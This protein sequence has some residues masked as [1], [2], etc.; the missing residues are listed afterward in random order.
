[1]NKISIF[2]V[3]SL[4]SGCSGLKFS[5]AQTI[6]SIES[7]YTYIPI[8]PFSVQATPN[9]NCFPP[10]AAFLDYD[11]EDYENLDR[12]LSLAGVQK[13]NATPLLDS[14][15]D[16]AVRMSI[17]QFDLSGT[18]NYG[19]SDIGARNESYRITVDYVNSDTSEFRVGI[20]KTA[21]NLGTGD[22]DL[23]DLLAPIDERKYD[24]DSI[25]YD[26]A[27]DYYSK[28]NS[29]DYTEYNIPVYVGVGLRV[30]ATVDVLTGNT[31]ISGLGVIGAEAEANNLKGSLV[32]QTLGING[33]SIAAALPIQSELNRTTAQNAI[34]A[35]GAIKAL[36]Y[37]RE[38][39]KSPRIVG[40][41]LPF[42]GGKALVNNIISELSKEGS[43]FWR[44]SCLT[45]TPA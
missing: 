32:I 7:G 43:V 28:A 1:M 25:S 41:Y 4:I 20:A 37:D 13:M 27:T 24:K 45:P 40:M 22:R 18:V 6:A 36:L 31:N 39:I 3:L 29:D 26:V 33:N 2:L 44:R 9:K 34:V 38:T 42:P 19:V 23:I 11:D 30:T 35:V 21:L 15:P 17:E 14:L 12:Q 16:N 8:D 10:E 5:S